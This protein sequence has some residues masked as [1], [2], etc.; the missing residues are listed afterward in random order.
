MN[1]TRKVKTFVWEQIR[2]IFYKT[3]PAEEAKIDAIVH[4]PVNE[5]G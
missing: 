4:Q 1:S 3:E 2:I 5:V